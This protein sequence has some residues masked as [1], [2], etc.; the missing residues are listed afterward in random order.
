MCLGSHCPNETKLPDVFSHIS[1]SD[2][3][4]TSGSFLAA[5][6]VSQHLHFQIRLVHVGQRFIIIH[7]TVNELKYAA[8]SNKNCSTTFWS[9][10][11]IPRWACPLHFWEML[12][13][14]FCAVPI[15]N[16]STTEMPH[17]MS[18]FVKICRR[19][20]LCHGS[21]EVS[22]QQSWNTELVFV[23]STSSSPNPT[24]D[25]RLHLRFT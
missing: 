21:S 20:W 15:R 19:L 14:V 9:S 4:S 7:K 17:K 2:G 25:I 1:T 11:Q 12:G 22:V 8:S 24:F 23:L 5:S 16:K 10:A 13:Y 18:R 6:N 3:R